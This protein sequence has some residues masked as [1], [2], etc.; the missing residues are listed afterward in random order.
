[1]TLKLKPEKKDR[2]RE[3]N[4]WS[5]EKEEKNIIEQKYTLAAE[6]KIWM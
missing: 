2:I 5:N 6:C 4:F 1:M 3:K